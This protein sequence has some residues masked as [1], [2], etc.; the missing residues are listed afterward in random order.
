MPE[1]IADKKTYYSVFAVLIVLLAATVGVAYVHLGRLN[2]FAAL[3]I[4]FLKAT[5]IVFYFMHVRYSS[6]L[7]WIFAGAG[8]FWLGIMFALSFADYFSRHWLPAPAGWN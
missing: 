7:V 3:S 5:L 8:F 4:A 2:V 1:H 6:R